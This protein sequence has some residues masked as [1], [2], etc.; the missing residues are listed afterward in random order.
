MTRGCLELIDCMAYWAEQYCRKHAVNE[1]T[2]KQ[3]LPDFLKNVYYGWNCVFF[4][5]STLILIT[6]PF[7]IIKSV[8]SPFP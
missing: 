2:Y 6:Q 1:S 8:V 4:N 7:S 5:A 3:I